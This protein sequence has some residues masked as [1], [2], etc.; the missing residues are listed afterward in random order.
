MNNEAQKYFDKKVS[1]G[2]LN[3]CKDLDYENCPKRFPIHTTEDAHQNYLRLAYGV[4]GEAIE[5]FDGVTRDMCDIDDPEDKRT[6]LQKKWQKEFQP[7]IE[8]MT[9]CWVEMY[10]SIGDYDG[11][12]YPDS[13]ATQKANDLE[14]C[15]IGF[16]K[17]VYMRDVK[18]GISLQSL[19][20]K[21]R[22]DGRDPDLAFKVIKR[23]PI[24]LNQD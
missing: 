11:V 2:I 20:N 21:M 9:D 17:S 5:A 1:R 24:T 15:Y 4:L 14:A 19:Y 10:D 16:L 3:L 13:E 18:N 8:K 22:D 23:L 6:P 7:F 12:Y